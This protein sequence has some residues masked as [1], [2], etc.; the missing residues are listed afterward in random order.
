M[1]TC[2]ECGK[3]FAQQ[4]SLEHHARAK[5]AD[6]RAAVVNIPKKLLGLAVLASIVIVAIFLINGN[7]SENGASESNGGNAVLRLDTHSKNLGDVSQSKGIV[8]TDFTI[9]NEGKDDLIIT[10]MDTSCMC[11]TARLITGGEE[12]PVYGMAVHGNPTSSSTIAPGATAKLRVYYDP[13][14]HG[15]I[16]G[17]IARTVNIKSNAGPEQVRINLNQVA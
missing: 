14:V 13:N 5:H 16:R 9:T 11:T 4:M 2:K 3:E 12:G 1:A 8:S 6:S 10:G 7:Q 15:E 17:P